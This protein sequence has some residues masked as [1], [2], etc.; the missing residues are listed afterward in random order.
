MKKLALLLM[1][2]LLLTGCGQRAETTPPLTDAAPDELVS[3]EQTLEP[4]SARPEKSEI[5]I[6]VQSK[7]EIQP[8]KLH[9][10][11]GYS[12]YITEEGWRL[13]QDLEDGR[14]IEDTWESTAHGHDAEL[15]VSIYPG[16]TADT[17]KARFAAEED[18]YLF[19]SQL[20]GDWGDPMRGRD[21][22]DKEML[23]FMVVE[24]NEDAYVIS[25][26]YDDQVADLYGAQ[27]RQMADTFLLTE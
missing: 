27:L 19:E 22:V 24:R 17:A 14:I 21:E 7:T 20:T 10:G 3:G 1:L 5:Q 26:H 6:T 16:V 18:D 8:V 12:I 11:Q 2:A 15:K 9:V 13:D 4:A 23:H 25:W